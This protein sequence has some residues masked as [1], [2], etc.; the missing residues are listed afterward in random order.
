MWK[1]AGI[2]MLLLAGQ[3]YG[4]QQVGCQARQQAVT[5]QLATARAHGNG[6][7]VAGLERALRN[8]ETGCTDVGLL[9]ESDQKLA[10]LKTKVDERLSELQSARVAGKPDKIAKKQGKLDEAQAKYQQELIHNGALRALVD[11]KGK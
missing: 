7:Q 11:S 10:E 9:E 2:S 4:N 5:E 3:A 6:E 1:L 8:I